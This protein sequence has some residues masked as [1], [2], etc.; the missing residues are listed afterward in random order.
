[1][2]LIRGIH[3]YQCLGTASSGDSTLDT[4]SLVASRPDPSPEGHRS[5]SDLSQARCSVAVRS[6]SA[7]V[8][9]SDKKSAH[10]RCM[11]C[12]SW[13]PL[14]GISSTHWYLGVASNHDILQFVDVQ[15]FS[16]CALFGVGD[17]FTFKKRS[18]PNIGLQRLRALSRSQDKLTNQASEGPFSV[19]L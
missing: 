5:V 13:L 4:E 19:H 9:R 3:R 14:H 6:H 8:W 15:L 12:V 1:M 11:R 10:L 16:L 18:W 17:R 7:R 2:S